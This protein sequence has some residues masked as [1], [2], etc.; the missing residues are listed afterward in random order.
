MAVWGLPGPEVILGQFY[1][2]EVSLFPDNFDPLQVRI[3]YERFLRILRSF[4][5][6]V[7]IIQDRLVETVE[8]FEFPHA[9][10]TLKDLI[11]KIE[12]KGL[13][14]HHETGRGYLN[15]LDLVEAFLQDDLQRL[16]ER[17]AIILNYLLSLHREVPLANTFFGRDQSNVLGDK[18]FFSR[19]RW[20]IRQREVGLYRTAYKGF[21]QFQLGGENVFLEG[22]DGIMFDGMCLIGAGGRTS[23]EAIIQITPTLL[24]CE[25]IKSVFAIVHPDLD[26]KK[27]TISGPEMSAMHLDTYFMPLR[28]NLVVCCLEEASKRDVFQV[29]N[30]ESGQ[31]IL[32]PQGKFSDFIQRQE[33][34]VIDVPI[35]EQRQHGTNFLVVND[36]IIIASLPENKITLQTIKSHGVFIYQGNIRSITNCGGGVHCLTASLKRGET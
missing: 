7:E 25:G 11:H 13:R 19:M 24:R 36:K 12:D 9:P 30:T 32:V 8:G 27:M 2:P 28:S 17:K 16:G 23:L 22:G 20:P 14:I 35:A 34:K 3:E 18:I 5:L 21:P 15:N 10:K 29:I 1:P 26:T 33:W 31:I 4:P 6:E